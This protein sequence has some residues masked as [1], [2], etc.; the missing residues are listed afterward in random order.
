MADEDLLEY[1][2]GHVCDGLTAARDVLDAT[3]AEWPHLFTIQL[4][5]LRDQIDI[6]C[7]T[8]EDIIEELR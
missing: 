5:E 6:A 3:E 7:D 4:A 1:R 8:A 2:I